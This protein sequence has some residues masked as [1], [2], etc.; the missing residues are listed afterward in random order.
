M[1]KRSKVKP[2]TKLPKSPK[3]PRKPKRV[4][5]PKTP[6]SIKAATKA[7][8]ARRK[9]LYNLS[10]EEYEAVLTYQNGRCAITG[11]LPATLSLAIDHCHKTGLIRGLLSAQ[12][13]KG[14]AIFQDN[15]DWLRRAAAYLENPPVSSAVGE[16][17]FG[18]IGRMTKKAANRRFGPP[19]GTKTPQSRDFTAIQRRNKSI[20]K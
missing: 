6:E 1:I 12:A 20:Q 7:Q 17:V 2:K 16:D 4:L 15:P 13:N 3:T 11:R 14:L 10:S 9:A 5:K 19:P 8:D 18:V